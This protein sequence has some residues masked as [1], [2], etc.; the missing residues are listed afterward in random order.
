[1]KTV[2]KTLIAM[3]IAGVA[4]PFAAHAQLEEIVVTA[5]KREQ[6][7]QDVSIAISAFDSS[8]L[9]ELGLTNLEQLPYVIPSVQLSDARGAGQ[10]TWVIRGAGLADFNANNTPV[11]AIFYD[12]VYMTSNALG[13]IG[14]FDVERVEVLKGPQGGLYGRNATG[15]AVRI[16]S[17]RPDL[18]ETSGFVGGTYGEWDRWTLEGAIGGP[19][20]ENT[21]A[22]RL[23]V[24]TDQGGGWQDSLATP[25]DDEHGDR[26]FQAIRGQLL[27]APS[28]ELEFLLKIDSGKD[29]SETTLAR[30]TGAYEPFFGYCDAILQGRRDDSTCLGFHN[31]IGDPLLPSDQKKNGETVLSNPINEL[32]NEW[33]GY[34]LY[35]DWDLGFADFKS[36]TSYYD[37]DYYQFFDYDATPLEIV[38]SVEGFPDADTNIEQWSQE[39]RLTSTGDGPLTW[40]A[41]AS[42]AEDTNE[43]IQSFSVQTLADLGFVEFTHGIADYTQDTEAWAVYGQ[44]GYDLTERLNL[45]GS[46]RYTDEDKDIDYLST[47]IIGGSPVPLGDVEG[48]ETSLDENWSGHIGLDW[49]VTDHVLL[50]ARFSRGVKSGGFFAAFTDNN[51]QLTPYAEEVND[52][53][54]IG[55]KSN[56][57]EELQINAAAFFYDYQDAQGGIQVESDGS[58]S[59][60]LSTIGTVGDAEHYGVEVDL[61]W[62][63]SALPGFQLGVAAAW[64]DAEIT[65]SD[66]FSLDLSGGLVGE[67]Q[68]QP[69]EGLDREYSPEWSYT[70]NARQEVTFADNLLGS[71]SAIYSWRDDPITRDMRLSDVDYGLI[72]EES[73]GLLSLRVALAHLDQ[74]W[75]IALRGD[76]LTDEEYTTISSGDGGGNFW[77]MP[78]RPASW[79]VELRYDF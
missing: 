67:N 77:D 15:G 33:T 42:Y 73:Y 10:P 79:T 59:G 37:Y 4:T 19:I 55:V 76:N 35:I 29:E 57:T 8:Q 11:A 75:E 22:Y 21:L 27:F 30:S 7:L 71:I 72:Q 65:D 56:P 53:F 41:G 38:T 74:G 26:D 32:D 16:L 31:L 20:I 45:H 23:A 54:E 28:D 18:S 2:Q 58:P 69:L 51:D 34:N 5:Q 1:M 47:L 78:G 12:E 48:F 9:T 40:L 63:P 44:V 17:A 62:A 25:G 66:E 70:I 46:L 13:G 39:F 6:S 52:S 3:A 49:S 24:N 61:V 64:L 68:P 60:T 36:I 14:L 50:Y 43:S